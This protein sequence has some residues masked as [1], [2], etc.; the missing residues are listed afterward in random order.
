M[1]LRRFHRNTPIHASGTVVHTL[2]DTLGRMSIACV[3]LSPD[4]E[5]TE[6]NG[7]AYNALRIG[8][9]IFRTR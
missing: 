8:G 6:I 1:K 3:T 7:Q 4:G 5:I 9:G 2:H